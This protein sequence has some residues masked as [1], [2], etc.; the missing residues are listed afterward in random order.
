MAPSAVGNLCTSTA[1][2]QL[3]ADMKQSMAL[4]YTDINPCEDFEQYAC[5]NWGTYHDIPQ[6]EEGIYGITVSQEQTYILARRILEDPYPTGDD[7]GYITVNLTKEQTKADKRNL[8]KIQEA[9]QVCQNYTAIEEEGLDVLSQLVETIVDLYPA[10]ASNATK[11]SSALTETLAFFERFG[12]GTFQQMFILQNEYDPKEVVA[13]I[14]PPLFSGM[15]LPTTNEGEAEMVELISALLMATHPSKLSNTTAMALAK[16]VYAFQVKL[17]SAW[18]WSVSNE[19]DDI[20]PAGNLKKLAPSLDYESVIEQLAPENWKGTITTV[21]PLYFTNMSEIVSQASS[22]TVQAFFVWQMISSV[23]SYIEHDLTNAYN[24]FQA[25]LQGKDPESPKP[26]W[27]NCV[28]LLDQGVDW[29]IGNALAESTTGPHGLTWILTRF[30]VDKNFGPDK[31]KTASDMVD[32]IKETFSD[33]IKT[34]E[35]ATEKVKKAALEKVEAMQKMIALPTD[36][37]PM[38]PIAIEKYYSDIEIRPSLVLNALAFARSRIAKHWKSLSEPY[39]RGQLIMTTLKANAYYA[40]TRNEVGLLAGY[41]QAPLFDPGYPDYINYG[42]AGSI[43]GHEIT[44]GFDSQGYMYD[45]TGNKT[46]WWDQESEEAFMNQT[47]CFIEQYSNFNITGPDGTNLPVNGSLTLPEN[48]ADAGG[49]VSGFAAWK[50]QVK[51]KGKAKNLPGLEEF[52]HEQLFFLKW[53][54]TWCSKMQPE[55]SLRLLTSDVH[56]PSAARALLPLRNSAEFN[57]AFKCSKKE[58][59][60][61]LW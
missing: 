5:G 1:C 33:R 48:I 17:V 50:K 57:K 25:K 53:G 8:A 37:N 20:V 44:H 47:K 23:S 30:F 7:A 39:S 2:L 22:Q 16:F 60:C 45:K 41:L 21:Q 12:I 19:P 55:L 59:V 6:G 31:I 42:G 40:P 51:D 14:S 61:E 52:S 43:V 3:A 26:R 10:T 13:G 24:N 11:N 54:Q 18:A 49:V 32:Y 9:Y 35:W 28:A 58:P 4:N 27:R 34:R 15:S 29:I 46:S 56:A 38:D 36:P